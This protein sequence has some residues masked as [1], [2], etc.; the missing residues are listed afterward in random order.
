MQTKG[1]VTKVGLKTP[2]EKKA[3]LAFAPNEMNVSITIL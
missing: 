1:K 3:S 2:A